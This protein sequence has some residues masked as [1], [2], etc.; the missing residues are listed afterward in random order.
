MTDPFEL[1]RLTWFTTVSRG[2]ERFAEAFNGTAAHA[3]QSQAGN[4][5]LVDLPR[6]RT[7][8]HRARDDVPS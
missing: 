1:W 5:R 6:I 4:Y 7:R 8:S 2:L 3:L